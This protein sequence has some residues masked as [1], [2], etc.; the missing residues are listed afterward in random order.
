MKISASNIAWK[1]EYDEQ[2]IEF[3]SQNGCEGLEIAPTRI[4]EEAP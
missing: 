4:F 3:L 2:M 1:K